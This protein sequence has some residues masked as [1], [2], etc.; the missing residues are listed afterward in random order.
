MQL[1]ESR[2]TQT[3]DFSPVWV[4]A[5]YQL[6]PTNPLQ[7]AELEPLQTQTLACRPS[8]EP[9]DALADADASV[10]DVLDVYR[11][12]DCVR[13]ARPRDL[14]GFDRETSSGRADGNRRAFAG[15]ALSLLPADGCDVRVEADHFALLLRDLDGLDAQALAPRSRC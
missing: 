12:T 4:D 8:G 14:D 15:R 9:T 13:V 1:I 7:V 5:D 11:C 6:M 2:A 10:A 3:R